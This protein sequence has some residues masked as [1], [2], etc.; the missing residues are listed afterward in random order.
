MN[1]SVRPA[2]LYCIKDKYYFEHNTV[3]EHTYIFIHFLFWFLDAF[4]SLYVTFAF[5]WNV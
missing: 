4:F 2:S 1:H 5:Q 3:K